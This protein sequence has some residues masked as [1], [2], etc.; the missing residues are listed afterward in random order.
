M[1]G[2]CPSN[3][4]KLKGGVSCIDAA[5]HT[6]F[7]SKA[8]CKCDYYEQFLPQSDKNF[9]AQ[10]D[11]CGKYDRGVKDASG[12]VKYNNQFC[13]DHTQTLPEAPIIMGAK[14]AG[15]ALGINADNLTLLAIGGLCIGCLGY[16]SKLIFLR[17][18]N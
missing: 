11:W 7:C 10:V 17:S 1:A 8:G 16:D 15:N 14:Q 9:S 6:C 13:Q 18:K 2:K 4:S 3:I 12:N 5:G